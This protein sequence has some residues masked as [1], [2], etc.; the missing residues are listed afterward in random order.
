M[1]RLLRLQSIVAIFS[2][3]HFHVMLLHETYKRAVLVLGPIDELVK[4]VEDVL[5]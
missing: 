2:F 4:Q 1:H 3:R 5:R